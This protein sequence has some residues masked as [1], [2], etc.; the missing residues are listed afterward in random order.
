MRQQEAKDCVVKYVLVRNE[1]WHRMYNHQIEAL[2]AAKP[3][4]RVEKW[5]YPINEDGTCG[6]PIKEVKRDVI[7]ITTLNQAEEDV[8]EF[9]RNHPLFVEYDPECGITLDINGKEVF[10]CDWYSAAKE[11]RADV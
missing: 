10:R 9:V 11:L 4:D 5:S 7:A 6:T 8:V 1:V 2:D 3:S